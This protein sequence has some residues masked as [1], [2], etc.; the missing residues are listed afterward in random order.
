MPL[1]NPLSEN[2]AVLRPS[3]L[4]GLVDAVAHNRRHGPRDV[5]LFEIGSRF[6]PRRGAAP[7]SRS[8]GPAPAA[9]STGAAARDRSTSSTSRARSSASAR[10]CGSRSSSP[11]PPA[12]SSWRAGRRV[13]VG[14]RGRSASLGLLAPA[15]AQARDAA[16][17]R[18][19]VRRG[20]RP[21][22]HRR[23]VPARGRAGRAA[24]PRFPSVVR[25]LSIVVDE[26]LPAARVR[27][28]IRLRGARR[29]S[30]ACGS[31]TATRARASRRGAAACRSG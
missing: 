6:S 25:D 30:S 7:A 28:T 26:T 29:R 15:L 20:A 21:R 5:R 14:R 8:P 10:R 18:R 16:A 9:P 23:L 13:R 1:A 22:R 24:L 4:P 19:G 31:S 12:R 11:P 17:G 2:F 27:G 3:L